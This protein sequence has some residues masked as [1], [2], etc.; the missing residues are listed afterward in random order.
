[1]SL[2]NTSFS[3]SEIH[4]MFTKSKQIFLLGIG[5]V[6]MSSIA[7]FLAFSGKKIFGYDRERG[8]EAIKLEQIGVIRYSSTPDN[9]SGMDIVIYT[10]AISQDSF[11]YREA[12][13]L[14][15]PLISRAN[16]LGYI[17]SLFKER[18]GVSG[19]HGKSTTTALLAHI[20]E[21]ACLN[22]TV[23]C[24]AKMKEFDSSG[25]IGGREWS[26][27]EA[28]EYKNSF[29]YLFPT[30]AAV[31]NI[32]LDHPDFF[33]SADDVALS[34]KEYIKGAE[35]VFINGDDS[36]ARAL[37]HKNAITFGFGENCIYR[38]E[39][40]PPKPSIELGGRGAKS[41][42]LVFR[43]GEL[44]SLC[45]LNLFGKH[46]VY[47]A[48]CAFCVAYENGIDKSVIE[49]AL[50]DFSGT[51]RRM[52]LI[53]ITDTGKS[54]FEDYAHHPTEIRASLSSL[55]A[56]G[57]KKV[58]CVFQAHTYS[59]TYYLYSEFKGAFECADEVIFAPIFSAR[60]KNTL[61]LSEND[62]AR[63]CGAVLIEDRFE[64]LRRALNSDADCVVFM[65]AGDIGQFAKCKL[66]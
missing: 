53:K 45:T 38:A 43:D 62:F 29:L 60:E 6:S 22:P 3:I 39:I 16:F 28:C 55:K 23:F 2:P 27:F 30:Q 13:R 58:L 15:I 66:Q 40:I 35:R 9:V 36:Y 26:I 1:M 19:I 17:L 33:S 61:P 37:C 50:S 56:Q 46:F 25:K 12:K 65:G 32:E 8:R 54:I 24:G 64:I 51:E 7:T 44:L 52:E 57:F 41:R 5:G 18:I 59:R 14:G 48:L 49:A 31:L 10:N 42:F 20:F 4:N 11:E 63:D 34:F 47:D 21:Y